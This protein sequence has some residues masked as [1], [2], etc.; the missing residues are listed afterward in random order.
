MKIIMPFIMALTINIIVKAQD[1]LMVFPVNISYFGETLVHPGVSFSY[2]HNLKRNFLITP[3]LGTYLHV[4]NHRAVFMDACFSWRKTFRFGYSMEYGIGI[5]YFHTW[6]HGGKT[7]TVNDNDETETK[8][9]WGRPNIM[10]SV[11]IGLLGWDFRKKTKLPVR[12]NADIIAFGQYPFNNFTMPHAA[13]R[14]GFTYYLKS[15]I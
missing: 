10:P 6:E 9:K 4:K 1:S 14:L 12:V 7:Y 11:K 15:K 2:E 13:L 3:S 8:F 5:G